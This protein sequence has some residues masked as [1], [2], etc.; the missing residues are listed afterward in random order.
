MNYLNRNLNSKRIA[1]VVGGLGAIGLEAS[2]ALSDSGAKVIIIDVK[3]VDKKTKVII[4]KYR[5]S[6]YKIKYLENE[7]FL[8]RNLKRF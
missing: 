5:C 6:Y 2:K 1:Y 3:K 7:K 4:K 8:E